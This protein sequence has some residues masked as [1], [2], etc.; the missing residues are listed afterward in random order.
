[1]SSCAKWDYPQ[2]GNRKGAQ[3]P[4]APALPCPPRP[5]LVPHHTPQPVGTV[6]T[7]DTVHALDLHKLET[8]R[9]QREGHRFELKRSRTEAPRFD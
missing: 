4:P 2:K 8:G 9:S 5:A 3:I 1:M 6:D 7:M